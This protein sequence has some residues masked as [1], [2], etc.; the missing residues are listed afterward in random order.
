MA[1]LKYCPKCNTSRECTKKGT[2]SKGEQLYFCKTC[3]KVFPA[4]QAT[5]SDV[6]AAKKK[7]T[8]KV[9]KPQGTTEIVV[10]NNIIKTVSGLLSVDQAFDMASTY[11]KEIVKEK[12]EISEKFNKKIIKFKITAGGKG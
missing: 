7:I 4:S 10:N 8:T 9:S 12:V 6:R 1:E 11:F 2:N 5:S 3:G